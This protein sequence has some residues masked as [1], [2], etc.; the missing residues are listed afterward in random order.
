VPALFFL[1]M[2]E[3]LLERQKGPVQ[4]VPPDIAV[5]MAAAQSSRTVEE[6]WSHSRMAEEDREM[7][8]EKSRREVLWRMR[9]ESTDCMTG[10]SEKSKAFYERSIL[11][12]GLRMKLYLA[13][14]L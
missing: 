14:E 5:E 13:I 4:G 9:R 3:K 6:V 1:G 2:Q 10:S 11:S 12:K 8:Q 7:L